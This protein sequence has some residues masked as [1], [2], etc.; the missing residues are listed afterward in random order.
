MKPT[1]LLIAILGLFCGA[2]VATA[3]YSFSAS[4][5]PFVGTGTATLK[6]KPERMRVIIPLSAQAQT[7]REAATALREK[8]DS[9]G[10]QLVVMGA[11][12][13]SLNT[14]RLK[15][16]ESASD[17]HRKMLMQMRGMM[18]SSFGGP[19]EATETTEDSEQEM[20]AMVS[21]TTSLT[22]DF[23]LQ[24]DDDVDLLAKSFE[25][26]QAI[27]D[28]KLNGEAGSGLSPEEQELLEEAAMF[29][30]SGEENPDQPV[31]MFVGSIGRD[32][33]SKLMKEAFQKASAS[34]AELAEATGAKLGRMASVRE[35]SD[36]EPDW[37]SFSSGRGY[38]YSSSLYQT[39]QQAK[40]TLD[41]EEG[42]TAIGSNPTE[43]VFS[44]TLTAG[45]GIEE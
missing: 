39:L 26:Q 36:M 27:K 20:A 5:E 24:G 15:I 7:V 4:S 37:D 8:A 9:A 2:P 1:T 40:A 38:G 31:F 44:V 12:S 30:Q 23:M 45:F 28:A 34:A 16:D 22:A 10:Q 3:Q 17:T 13:D 29:G 41:E 25:L 19:P 14:G 43:L 21:V 42:M 33:R 6:Q 35:S 11:A 32:A 18:G